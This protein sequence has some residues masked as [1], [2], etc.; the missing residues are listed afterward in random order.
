MESVPDYEDI[1]IKST[2]S[3]MFLSVRNIGIQGI[4]FIG[5]FILT[6]ILGPSEVG[7]FAIVVETISVLGYFSDVG[8]ASALIQKKE[9]PTDKE[10][11]S[12]F[13][14]QQILV[15]SSL[16]IIGLLYPSIA[17]ARHYGYQEM[18]IFISLGFGFLYPATVL[19]RPMARMGSAA[20]G[21]V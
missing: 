21:A 20:S 5:Y 7:L 1:K 17:L 11:E 4:S 16:I 8:L 18:W 19:W 9:P 10:L 13:T 12:S 15:I 6:V 3:I 14:L 2:K